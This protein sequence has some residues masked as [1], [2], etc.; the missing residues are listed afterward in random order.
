[1]SVPQPG[2]LNKTQAVYSAG[3]VGGGTVINGLVR[4]LPEP[5]WERIL[6]SFGTA[7]SSSIEVL[8][9]TMMVGS[10]WETLAGVGLASYRISRRSMPFPKRLGHVY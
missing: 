6:T 2:L 4:S 8:L 7:S 1:M 3:V 5:A 9:Q 10:Y